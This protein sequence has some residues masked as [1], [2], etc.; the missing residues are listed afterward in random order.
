DNAE[1][2]RFELRMR[3]RVAG[4]AEYRLRPGAIEFTHT[5]V[6]PALRGRGLAAQL[7][8]HALDAAAAQNL[9][10]TP[11]CSYVAAYLAKHPEYQGLLDERQRSALGR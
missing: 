10:V 5:E 8:R 2:S 9:Q 4:F 1:Q 7:M 6:D 3:G 11:S